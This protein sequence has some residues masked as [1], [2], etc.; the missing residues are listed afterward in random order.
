MKA[1]D[2][3]FIIKMTKVFVQKT[4][5]IQIKHGVL[6]ITKI[7]LSGIGNYAIRKY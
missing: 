2:I 4:A 5:L 7:I 3:L 6:S 1:S